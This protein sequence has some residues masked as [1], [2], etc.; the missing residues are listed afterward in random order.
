MRKPRYSHEAYRITKG[1]RK[2]SLRWS[3]PGIASEFIHHLPDLPEQIRQR[4]VLY[5]RESTPDQERNG[6]LDDQMDDAIDRLRKIGFRMGRNLWVFDGVES[7]RI[8]DDRLLLERALAYARERDAT[9]VATSRD[10]FI[11]CSSFG[12]GKPKEVEPPTIAEYTDLKD[13]A[14]DVPLATICHPDDPAARSDQ[15]RR[16]QRAKGRKG[17]RPRKNEKRR[18]LE[19]VASQRGLLNAVLR[20][21]RTLPPDQGKR[22]P[23][24][25]RTARFV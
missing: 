14:G 24:Q 7:S 8:Q 13:L 19:D 11:R 21:W 2:W 9:L 12:R 5:C 10:R 6:N 23:K 1:G 17:G 3:T 22:V 15:I 16:G 25:R 18:R 20:T 4:V